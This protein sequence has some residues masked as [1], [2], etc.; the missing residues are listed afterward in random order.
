MNS[1]EQ[2]AR[3]KGGSSESPYKDLFKEPF[4]E[5]TP[6]S[7]GSEAVPIDE[8]PVPTPT[9]NL[10]R[11]KE[12]TAPK[13]RTTRERTLRIQAGCKQSGQEAIDLEVKK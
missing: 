9:F 11:K 5:V 13:K 10:S 3:E 2:G 6:S 8:H 4:E 12:R 1:Q 7:T